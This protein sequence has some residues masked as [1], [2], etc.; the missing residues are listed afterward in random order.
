[1]TEAQN[2]VRQ[3]TQIDFVVATDQNAASQRTPIGLCADCEHM[4]RIVSDRGS[5][6]YLCAKALTEPEFPKYPR[7][8]VIQCRGYRAR[9]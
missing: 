1:M 4:R 9:E 6:F 2:P 5:A 3:S 7:L 8:P